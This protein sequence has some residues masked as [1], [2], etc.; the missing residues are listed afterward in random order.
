MLQCKERHLHEWGRNT[1]LV[2]LILLEEVR[3]VGGGGGGGGRGGGGGAVIDNGIK[4]DHITEFNKESFTKRGTPSR[5]LE[6]N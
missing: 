5:R 1:R 6:M 2:Q 3:G 4:P